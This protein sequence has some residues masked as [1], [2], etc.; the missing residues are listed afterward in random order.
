MSLQ[1]ELLE[2]SFAQIK[3]RLAEFGASFYENLFTAYP[4][5]RPLFAK[6]DLTRQQ[7]KL[8]QALSLVI[9]HLRN[10]EVLAETLMAL[11][12]KHVAYG[13]LPEHY[14]LVGQ[15]LLTTLA[16]TL[17]EGWT[18]ELNRAWSQAYE[19]VSQLMLAGAETGLA[20][21]PRA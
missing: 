10:D 6:T 13:A 17:G 19:A 8:T 21:R 11:G 15:V 5:A 2:S 9:A 20:A 16:Q 1:I 14:P 7:V 18:P 4:Q 3:P 12:A